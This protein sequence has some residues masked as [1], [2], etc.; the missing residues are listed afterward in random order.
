M[1]EDLPIL[2]R[3]MLPT[4]RPF[5]L[6]SWITV[7]CRSNPYK[8]LAVN[9]FGFLTGASHALA[10][11]ILERSKVL[12]ACEPDDADQIYGYAV[13]DSPRIL[14]WVHVKG[15]FRRTKV[16]TRLLLAAFQDFETPISATFSSSAIK[17]CF[18]AWN[19]TQDADPLAPIHHRKERREWS[20][21]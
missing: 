12:I 3:P 8:R 7:I 4:D 21:G 14:H 17:R 13:F 6:N 10:S 18:E 19:L 5:I 11:R 15:V 2:I 20:Y 1:S 9:H 16:G